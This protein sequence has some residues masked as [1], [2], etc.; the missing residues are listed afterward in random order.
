M[1]QFSYSLHIFLEHVLMMELSSLGI[2]KFY[3]LRQ[4]KDEGFSQTNDVLLW[5]NTVDSY[6]NF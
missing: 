2:M 5:F 4:C 1:M 6:I 3:L